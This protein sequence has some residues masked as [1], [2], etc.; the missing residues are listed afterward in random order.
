MHHSMKLKI[1][2]K[3]QSLLFLLYFLKIMYKEKNHGTFS[4]WSMA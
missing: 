1:K 3:Q 4:R 2:I